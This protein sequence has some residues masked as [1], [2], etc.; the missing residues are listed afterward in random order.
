MAITSLLIFI[1]YW[2]DYQIKI[3]QD[4]RE[5]VQKLW[6]LHSEWNDNTSRIEKLL[7]NSILLSAKK[8]IAFAISSGNPIVREGRKFLSDRTNCSACS[9]TS[10]VTPCLYIIVVRINPGL[11]SIFRNLSGTIFPTWPHSREHHAQ[12]FRRPKLSCTDPMLL[13]KPR[14]RALWNSAN[15]GYLNYEGR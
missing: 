2:S 6:A 4:S 5:L 3:E 1:Y 13:L 15:I 10:E 8:A 14:N 12:S 7:L 9:I 11:N